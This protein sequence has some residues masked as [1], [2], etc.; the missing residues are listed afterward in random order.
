M[1]AFESLVALLLHRDGYWTT[2]GFKVEL[3]KE[4]KRRIGRPSSP[5]WELD[6]IGYNLNKLIV[7]IIELADLNRREVGEA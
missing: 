2:T 7:A 5:R 4:E 6:V 1:D 3:T